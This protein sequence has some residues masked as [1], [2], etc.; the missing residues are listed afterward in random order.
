MSEWSNMSTH[1]LLFQWTNSVI[2]KHYIYIYIPRETWKCSLQKTNFCGDLSCKF[3]WYQCSFRGIVNL[4]G[5][6]YKSVWYWYSFRV[7][8]IVNLLGAHSKFIWFSLLIS[9]L[10]FVRFKAEFRFFLFRILLFYHYDSFFKVY[11]ILPILPISAFLL[12]L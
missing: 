4:F 9:D 10:I 7:M 11:S 1:G 12:S 8:L 5:T 2:M 6:H 3:V